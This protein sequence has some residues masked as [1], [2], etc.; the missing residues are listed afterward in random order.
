[1]AQNLWSIVSEIVGMKIGPDFES[2]AKMWL[3]DKKFKW[4]NVCSAAVLWS[5]WKIR[6]EMCFHGSCWEGMAKLLRRCAGFLRNWSVLGDIEGAGKLQQWAIEMER[7]IASPLALPWRP[8]PRDSRS[9]STGTED[10]SLRS[11]CSSSELR[12]N[13]ISVPCMPE[14][15]PDH[16]QTIRYDWCAFSVKRGKPIF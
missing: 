4:T 8:H 13:V 14:S 2:M 15:V 6:N 16:R 1:V 7:R 10:S 5:L 12:N 11:L 9:G 3:N